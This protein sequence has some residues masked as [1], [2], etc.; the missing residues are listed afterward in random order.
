MTVFSRGE[1]FFYGFLTA[2]L[3]MLL[4]MVSCNI[5]M[6]P[7]TLNVVT[8]GPIPCQ[9]LSRTGSH[10]DAGWLCKIPL[11]QLVFPPDSVKGVWW[12]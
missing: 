7:G 3:I 5:P 8:R 4:L 6:R 11:G 12:P 1:S 10:V 9:S 2:I